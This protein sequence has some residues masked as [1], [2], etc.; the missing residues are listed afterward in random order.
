VTIPR[1]KPPDE[2]PSF[3]A[4]PEVYEW[5]H[6]TILNTEHEWYN[7]DH[8]HLLDYRVN[9]IAFLW[10]QGGYMKK[11]KWVL[12]EC[13]KVMMMA[14]GWKRERQE[15]WFKDTLGA[16]PDYLITLD[17]SY[18][19]DCTD[20]EFAALVEHELYHISH[21]TDMFGDPAF[22]KDGKPA[23]EI[24]SHDVEEFFGVV[25]RYGGDEAV[26]KMAELQ[27]CEP[28]IKY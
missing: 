28:K 15:M 2:I 22:T 21:K 8:K 14:G 6:S 19:R 11:N 24:T 1:P 9:E 3:L 10:A 12:G 7:D 27:D 20:A 16:V 25:R 5:L 18:C 23:L 17:A 13:E 26:I 4:A